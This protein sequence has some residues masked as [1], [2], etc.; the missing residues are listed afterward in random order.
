M[1]A[2]NKWRAICVAFLTSCSVAQAVE[3]QINQQRIDKF[4]MSILDGIQTISAEQQT[5]YCGLIAYYP[6]G[7][8]YGTEP[9]KGTRNSCIVDLEID[10]QLTVIASYHTHGGYAENADSEV[11]SL[12]DLEG[13]IK[14]GIDGYIGTPGGRVWFNSHQDKRAYL[15]CGID[16]IT[17]DKNFVECYGFLPAN[18]Y[19]IKTLRKRINSDTGWC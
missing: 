1:T 13:D 16:C 14:D 3:P 11:P 10:A 2:L 19:T 4:A 6:D 17:S 5:E 18:S 8:L 15:L 12:E 7:T 9:Q